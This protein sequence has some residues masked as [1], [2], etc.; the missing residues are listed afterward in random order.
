M[1]ISNTFLGAKA[2]SHA[3]RRCKT[4]FFVGI[5]GIQMEA[6]AL[7]LHQRGY[8]VRGSDREQSA[9]TVRLTSAG[10]P[11]SIGHRAENVKGAD[12]VF[13]TLAVDSE[14]PELV[15]ARCA[16]IPLFS[17]ADLLGALMKE[18]P[19]RIA[20]A[21]MHGKST[22]TAMFAAILSAAGT[23]PTVVG[24]APLAPKGGA[25]LLGGGEI[26]LCEACEYRDSFLC[27]DPTVAII[28][29]TE[30]EHTDYFKS[31][32]AVARSFSRFASGAGTVI[33]P[34]HGCADIHLPPAARIIRFGLSEAADA[35][36]C[37]VTYDGGCPC[38]SYSFQGR[39]Y[40]RVRLS[41][42]GE[43][44]VM[45][46][47]AAL[48]AA[49]ILGVPFPLAAAALASFR[50]IDRR[51]QEKGVWRGMTVYEDY[52]HHPTEIRASLAALRRVAGGGR[53]FCIYQA[54]TFSR[55]ESF[56]SEFAEALS[57][58]DHTVYLDIYAA[59]EKNESGV[60]AA[61]LA[62]ATKN[63]SYAKDP[64][65][66]LSKIGQMARAGDTLVVMGAGDIHA[67]I[68]PLLFPL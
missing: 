11:V 23:Q 29:N 24:G 41:V 60:S 18:A 49:E 66:A 46:A 37:S 51:L 26:F 12:C 10:I 13:Y 56:F 19:T 44:N 17:R 42:L 64:A 50:G 48:A 52:A 30:W 8:V 14:N 47:T 28:L 61:A 6:L 33:L 57:A 16:G 20:V 67:R 3:L 68:R 4:V 27:L 62:K 36:A 65:A 59:R 31:A 54:H 35:R 53:L 34:D 15:A 39:E 40:G 7:L 25:Y 1:S 9:A 43:H 63:A 22:A 45:N 2:I 21:G 55:T 5:G 58:S 38:F 32:S